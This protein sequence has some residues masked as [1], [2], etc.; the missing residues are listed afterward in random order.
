LFDGTLQTISA[1][2]AARKLA[3][4]TTFDNGGIYT[5]VWMNNNYDTSNPNSPYWDRAGQSLNFAV[6]AV[7]D[8]LHTLYNSA[9]IQTSTPPPTPNTPS[10][11]PTLTP[12][13]TPTP[14][15]TP[16]PTPKPTSTPTSTPTIPPTQTPTPTAS[17]TS[18]VSLTPTIT[19]TPPQTPSVM[20]SSS[21]NPTA[22]PI[23]PTIPE[24]SSGV[25]L[26]VVAISVVLFVAIIRKSKP[27]Q[28][29]RKT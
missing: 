11:S 3:F 24:F 5:C 25:V 21:L 6:N 28:L 13:P 19:S 14:N 4:D 1:Y 27:S 26:S 9:N 20:P 29:F 23:L 2:D 7:T 15:P 22:S 16:T 18:S 12:T 17:P 8:V 10:L